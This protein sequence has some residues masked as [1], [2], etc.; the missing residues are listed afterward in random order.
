VS[1]ALD[2]AGSSIRRAAPWILGASMAV[3]AALLLYLN[4]GTTFYIDEMVW[5]SNLSEPIS[6]EAILRP[7]NSHLIG[8]SR[9]VYRLVIEVAG[10]DYLVFRILGVLGVMACSGVLFVWARRRIGDAWALLPAVLLLFY[11]SAW[12]HVVG[13]IGFTITVSIAFGIGALICLERNDRRGDTLACVLVSLSV[14]TYTVGLGYLV[15]VA[16]S[17]LIR[18]DRWRR[19]WIFLIPLL[20]YAAWWAWARQ[21]DQGRTSLANAGHIASYLALSLAVVTGGL[22][23]VG[24]A[25]SRLQDSGPIDVAPPGPLGWALAGALLLAV[26]WRIRRGGYSPTIFASLGVVLTYWLAAALSDPLYFGLQADSVRYVLPGSVGLLLVL[27]DA[28]KGIEPRRAASA[29]L[30]VAFVFSLGMN[31]L[32]LRDGAAYLRDQSSRVKVS[33]AMLELAN[34]QS[35]GAAGNGRS[36]PRYQVAPIIPF[37]GYGPDRNEY[38]AA[39]AKFGSPADTLEEV[40]GLPDGLRSLADDALV[41][42]YAMALN[43]AP[44]PPDG[45]GCVREA[46]TARPFVVP[47]GGMYVRPIG[48]DEAAVSVTRFGPPPGASLGAAAPGRWSWVLIPADQAPEQW[49]ATITAGAAVVCPV[50]TVP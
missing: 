47:P 12:Q 20:L 37:L 3:A 48:S 27:V 11:G 39:V 36:T 43:P 5:F 41:Q 30:I 42:A 46:A 34:G 13:P 9:L 4:R 29:A 21:F 38:L 28:A 31:L 1:F 7:H 44:R 15:G 23:G 33:L 14:F 16:I 49:T 40:R 35:P 18:H 8:L 17:V 22:S 32:F 19:A 2:G 24:A 25:F 45:A 50:P 10:P 6:L 26:T